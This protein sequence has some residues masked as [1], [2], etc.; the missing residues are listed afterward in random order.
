[1]IL[2]Y[3]TTQNQIYKQIHKRMYESLESGVQ[4]HTQHLTAII[5]AQKYAGPLDNAVNC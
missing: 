3:L 5:Q 4:K 2:T 1:M